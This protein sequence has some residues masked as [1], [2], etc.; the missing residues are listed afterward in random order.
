MTIVPCGASPSLSARAKTYGRTFAP[1]DGANRAFSRRRGRG[2]ALKRLTANA[3]IHGNSRVAALAAASSGASDESRKSDAKTA[4]V[5]GGGW[6]GFGAMKALLNAGWNVKLFDASPDPAALEGGMRNENGRPV[7][8]GFKGFWWQYPNIFSLMDELK[9]KKEDVLTPYTRSGLYTPKGLYTQAPIFSDLPRLPAPFGQA[10]YTSAL[11]TDL[12]LSD[13]VTIS[14]LLLEM[15]RYK[16]SEETYLKYDKMTAMQ[17]FKRAGVSDKLIEG[18]LRPI[19]LVGLFKP[20]EELSAALVMDMLYYYAIGHQ[21]DFD[22][23]WARA[24]IAEVLIKPLA[25]SLQE[26]AEEKGLE[27]SVQGNSL[28]TEVVVENSEK[29][30]SVKILRK[31][32]KSEEM[33][34]ADAVVLAVGVTGMKKI[35]EASP[36]LAMASPDLRKTAGTMQAIDVISTRLWLDKRV[37]CPFPSNV[38]AAYPELEGAGGT[39]F[40]LDA[41]HDDPW[42]SEDKGKQG[43]VIAADFYNAG[44]LLT[45]TDE[46]LVRR[47][48]DVLLPSAVPEFGSAKVVDVW[49]KRF[50]KA[51]THFAP[52]SAE[53][54][55]PQVIPE[56]RNLVVAG[57]LVKGLEHG[58]AG[59]SQ[60]RAY[61]SGLA[62]AN[63]LEQVFGGKSSH[64]I[65]ATEEDEEQFQ[66]L[67]NMAVRTDA[68]AR[69]LGLEKF[70]GV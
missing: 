12:P 41:L 43:S 68:V 66:A 20:P 52:G 13:R 5:I 22:V 64:E 53:A 60:E 47:V 24:P 14:G 62:A 46:E 10:L 19:L 18:F 8:P 40:C 55:P 26:L 9:L 58:S 15:V 27:A 31:G 25:Q 1:G 56:V 54:R 16:A 2:R 4:V 45:L 32:A 65:L 48:K 70:L 57:D 51:V 50:P 42:G 11:F 44:N 37:N 28:V 21:Y 34:Q 39:F 38:F 30:S 59:L 17:L 69:A 67:R 3:R 36:S 23:R 35:L 63:R 6:A 49:V 33:V 29:V 61:V 7:E